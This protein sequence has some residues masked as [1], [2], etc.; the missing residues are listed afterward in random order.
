M[1]E[2]RALEITHIEHVIDRI[3]GEITQWYSVHLTDETGDGP[4]SRVVITCNVDEFAGIAEAM[5][6]DAEAAVKF[7]EVVYQGDFEK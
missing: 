7:V 6:W 2:M 3:D 4:M 5:N 1:R